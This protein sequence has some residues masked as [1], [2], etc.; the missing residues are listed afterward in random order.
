MANDTQITVIGNLTGDPELRFTPNGAAVAN[1]TIANTP[2]VFDRQTGEWKE[3]AT[4]FLRASAWKE[5]AENA[6][7]SLTKGS[8]VIAQGRLKSRTYETKEGE[9]RT[10]ME[11]EVEDIGPSLRFA[12]AQVARTQR[13]GGFQQG[14]QQGWDSQQ[15]QP[16]G[17]VQQGY[18]GGGGSGQSPTG[19]P[20]AAQPG[21]GAVPGPG[22]GSAGGVNPWAE[23]AGGNYDWG[24]A[25]DELAPF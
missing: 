8:R 13:S 9:R 18:S 14:Q 6:A 1:F 5:L 25:G 4:L 10:S 19:T 22:E 20:S 7:A 15:N 23:H 3:G 21:Q 16:Q 17:Q 2:R 24:A 12:S 11:L